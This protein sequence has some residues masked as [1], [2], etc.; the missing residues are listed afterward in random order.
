MFLFIKVSNHFKNNN[1][2]QECPVCLETKECKKISCGHPL[3]NEC[4][5]KLK[6]SGR[7]QLSDTVEYCLCI[8][9]FPIE[10]PICRQYEIT[11]N[12]SNVIRELFD[13]KRTH[14]YETIY[15]SDD[16]SVDNTESSEDDTDLCDISDEQDQSKPDEP[17]TE[18]PVSSEPSL[19]NESFEELEKISS[20]EILNN[21]KL[22]TSLHQEIH[23]LKT[24]IGHIKE[25]ANG[26]FFVGL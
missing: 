15:Q 14:L 12:T 3:C 21:I 6:G 25:W 10:C 23:V 5:I 16:E 7:I 9:D 17:I 24:H 19:C 2:E 18:D 26:A 13:M 1:P 22:I 8:P 4:Y 11:P 20:R